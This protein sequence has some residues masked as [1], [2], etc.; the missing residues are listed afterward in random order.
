M[1]LS[2]KVLAT[3]VLTLVVALLSAG[4]LIGRTVDA[5]YRSYVTDYRRGQLRHAAAQAAQLEAAGSSWAEIQAWLNSGLGISGL[6]GRGPRWQRDEA[7]ADSMPALIIIDPVSG[8]TLVDGGPPLPPAAI[9]NATPIIIDGEIR[10]GL[11]ST[12]PLDMIGG[13]EQ[14]VLDQINRAIG[15]SALISGGVA[16]LLGALLIG[17]ILRPL[18]RLEAGV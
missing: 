6:G 13:A 9:E 10:G 17:S 12:M 2:T 1:N 15:L 11:V 5:T 8:A 7:M 3:L 18:R 14:A 4:L 16:L